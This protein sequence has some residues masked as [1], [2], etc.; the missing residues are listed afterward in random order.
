M[1]EYDNFF[2]AFVSRILI[3]EPGAKQ[4]KNYLQV[5]LNGWMKKAQHLEKATK[6]YLFKSKVSSFLENISL[7]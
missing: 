5:C 7:S 6:A 3:N 1:A 2:T 4:A